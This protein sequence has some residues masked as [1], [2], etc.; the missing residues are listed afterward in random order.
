MV[1]FLTEYRGLFFSFRGCL[2]GV[3]SRS[4]QR[5]SERPDQVRVNVNQVIMNMDFFCV[6]LINSRSF[7]GPALYYEK[8]S[9]FL[10]V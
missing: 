7:V 6:N 8:I 9:S 1:S 4:L 2:L 5:L 10:L 3:G